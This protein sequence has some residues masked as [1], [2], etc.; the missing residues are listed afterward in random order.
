MKEIITIGGELKMGSIEEL[1]KRRISVRDYSEES[2]NEEVLQKTEDILNT[3]IATPFSYKP[4]FK[5][6]D[7]KEFARDQKLKLGT[8][9]FIRGA[10]Y[11]IVGSSIKNRE[12]Y[13]DYGFALEKII[14]ELT[15]LNLGT[16]WLGGTFTKDEFG[17]TIDLKNNEL[18]PAVTPVGYTTQSGI[19][20]NL[21]RFAISASK[22]KPASELFF[23][24]EPDKDSVNGSENIDFAL[25]MVRLAPSASNKQPW[26]LFVEDKYINFYLRGSY[27]S[28]NPEKGVNLQWLD[29]GIAM[30]H[31][32][33]ALTENG[34]GGMWMVK[35]TDTPLNHLEYVS[36]WASE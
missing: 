11:F 14:L 10:R 5:L 32:Q 24:D 1:I 7:K 6:V 25:E 16:C 4:R 3:D 28:K 30:C 17:K 2:L 36:T 18:I 15:R 23:Y 31:L 9:G 35:K 29:I 27:P 12:A 34:I 13:I 26:R 21:V 19:R 8:Y 20:G 33:Y 22:R